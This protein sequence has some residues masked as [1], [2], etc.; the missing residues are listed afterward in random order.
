MTLLR[1]LRGHPC[2]ILLK[3][4]VQPKSFEE[5]NDLYLV[6][7]YVDTDLYKLI[8]SPQFL[9]RDHIQ[10][11]LWSLLIGLKYIHSFTIIHR[12]LKPANILLN[13]DCSL[14]I[15]DFGLSRIHHTDGAATAAPSFFEGDGQ[16]KPIGTIYTSSYM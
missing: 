2:I 5:F 6:F 11:F 15:C 7:E 1:R 16:I 3:D 10:T 13:E 9:T 14:K 4:V 12:D 8:M